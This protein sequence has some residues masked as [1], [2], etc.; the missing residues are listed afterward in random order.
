MR[1]L[2]LTPLRALRD[3]W[4]N[5]RAATGITVALLL[6]VFVG[7]AGFTID[8]GH[9]S[10]VQKE[11]QASTDAAALAGGYNI[12]SSTAVATANSYGA[13]SGAK[14]ALAGGVTATMITGFPVL[15]CLTSTGVGCAGTELAGGANAIQ[16]SEKAPVPMWFAEILGFPSF[17]LTATSTASA[18]GGTGQALN[19]MIVLDTTN[20]MQT[21]TDDNCGLGASATREQ[22]ALAGV[23]ALL[24]GLNPNLDYVG[25]MVFPGLQSTSEASQ[26]FTCGES[27]GSG[28]TQT[29]GASPVYQ[30]VG[31]SNNF[32]SSSKATTLN[33]GSD[34]VLAVGDAGCASGVSAPGGQ[35]TYYAGAIGAAQTALE[36]LS[37]TQTPPAQNVMVFLS[38]GGANSSTAESEIDGYM[39]TCTTS[40]GR[41]TCVASSTLTVSSCPKGCATSATSSVEGPLAA[42]QAIT[43]TGITSGTTIVKQ[44]TGTTGGAGAYQVS[45]SQSAGTSLN[46]VLMVAANPLSL[47]GLSFAQ[48]TDQCQQAIAAAQAAAKGGTWIYSVAYGSSTSTG[49]SSTCTTDSGAIISGMSGLSS[50]TTMQYIAN[51]PSAMPDP[52]K[53]YSNNNN[54]ADCPNSNT[55][56]NLVTL[57]SNLSTSLTEPRLIPNNTT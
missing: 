20:S 34:I 53:F 52:S 51:T 39:G 11:L 8:I 12:P 18:R 6:P 43:G 57:F 27:V 50:C 1:R 33:T 38:D 7:L 40:N 17:T 47:N 15:K 42:G 46:P 2:G 26:D 56:E 30:V 44:L 24:S 54:G 13:A 5:R 10:L 3:L 16:V 55:I 32:K 14:N 29:Y 22:C 36:A 48:N 9:L 45:A 49:G 35:G 21:S 37:S 4:S 31:L 25:L 19:V 28:G 41:T 23:Q